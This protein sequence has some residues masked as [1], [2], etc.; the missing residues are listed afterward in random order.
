MVVER[1]WVEVS[2]NADGLDFLCAVTA[3]CSR[4]VIKWLSSGNW[5]F[6]TFFTLCEHAFLLETRCARRARQRSSKKLVRFLPKKAASVRQTR[7]R[8]QRAVLMQF[9][10]PGCKPEPP[11]RVSAK[12]IHLTYAALYEH[13][14]DHNTI[15]NAAK[16]WGAHRGGLREYVIGEEEHPDP[17]DPERKIHYH[18]YL[19]FTT[20]VELRD[21]LH[22]TVF[23]L[24]GKDERILHPEVQAVKNHPADRERVIRYDM[25]DGKWRAEL[26]TAL[27][28]DPQRDQEEEQGEQVDGE[29]AVGGTEHKED[30]DAA[31]KWAQMLN[32]ANTVREGMMLLAEQAPQIYYMHGTRIES[33]LGKRVGTP[34]PKLY[35]LADFN[36]P[37]LDLSKPVVLSGDSEVGKTEFAVAHFDSPLIV[38]RR[39][40]LKRGSAGTDGIIFDDVNFSDWSPEDV[41]C[42]LQVDKPRSLPARYSDAFIEADTPMIFTTNKKAKKIF[43][44]GENSAQRR[45]IKRRYEEVRVTKPLQARGRPDTPA[46]KRARRE[47]GQNGAQGPP[48]ATRE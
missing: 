3:W 4:E 7:R 6:M 25:K 15:L 33:M 46:E 48:T 31:P 30:A 26:E 28:N 14:V 27:V 42:L 35:T 22:T 40:D 8:A 10:I 19:K 1:E 36:R 11:P 21:R 29:A 23:D 41:I 43:P 17:A 44:R 13:E 9:V 37:Q 12:M 47:P 38:R 24:K 2:R 16:A 34:E 5:P 18:A 32:K 45:A 20:K 39:D